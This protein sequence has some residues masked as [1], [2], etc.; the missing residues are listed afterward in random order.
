MVI[1]ISQ[2]DINNFLKNPLNTIEFPP[3]LTDQEMVYGVKAGYVLKE[4]NANSTP[5]SF[6]RFDSTM[7]CKV[8]GVASHSFD[9][10]SVVQNVSFV[11]N[12]YIKTCLFLCTMEKAQSLLSVDVAEVD[13]DAYHTAQDVASSNESASDDSAPEDFHQGG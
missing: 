4:I 13:S 8:C 7:K 5:S 10:C 9:A 3:D 6:K 2:V 12:A 11:K 1:P